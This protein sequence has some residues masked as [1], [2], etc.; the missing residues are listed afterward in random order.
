MKLASDVA[1]I[2][3]WYGKLPSLGDFASRRLE[4]DF[5]EPWDLWL[6]EAMQAQRDAMGDAWLDAYLQSP[7]WR[8]VLMPEV[9]PGFDPGLIL[10]GVLMP[11]VDRVGRYFPLTIAASIAHL[12]SSRAAYEALLAWLHRIEDTALDALQDD[13][14]IEQLEAALAGLAPPSGLPEAA[15]DAL[16][17]IRL[18]LAEALR[19]TGCFVAIEGVSSRTELASLLIGMAPPAPAATA[20]APSSV[21]PPL[22]GTALWLADNPDHPQL[23]VSKGLPT[24]DDFIRMFGSTGRE[25]GAETIY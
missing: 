15:G 18:A 14:T 8:F 10:V 24:T 7:P 5:I 19:G 4:A 9:L 6:G 20:A 22:A 17:P 1:T 23:L 13:W 11:S 3:G 16:E 21:P 25:P 2:P 12:P